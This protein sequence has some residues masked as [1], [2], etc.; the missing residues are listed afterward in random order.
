MTDFTRTAYSE[1]SDTQR[2]VFMREWIIQRASDLVVECGEPANAAA[3]QAALDYENY[4]NQEGYMARDGRIFAVRE[5]V[6]EQRASNAA[7]HAARDRGY[8]TE[9][10]ED[11][12]MRALAALE[13]Q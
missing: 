4:L 12:D 3:K 8:E 1:M 10:A 6:S 9:A 11:A 7:E 13:T 2:A 5:M